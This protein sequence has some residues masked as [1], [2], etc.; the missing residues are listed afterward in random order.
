MSVVFITFLCCG[1][2]FFVWYTHNDL[3]SVVTR[4]DFTGTEKLFTLFIYFRFTL[5]MKA[6]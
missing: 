1:N 5:Q 2:T 4:I 3:A 6:F